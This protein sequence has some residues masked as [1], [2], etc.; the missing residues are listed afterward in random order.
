MKLPPLYAAVDLKTLNWCWFWI[1]CYLPEDLDPAFGSALGRSF[2]SDLKRGRRSV[3]SG[4]WSHF[5]V[6]L[7]SCSVHRTV[8]GLSVHLEAFFEELQRVHRPLAGGSLGHPAFRWGQQ[9]QGC[10]VAKLPRWVQVQRPPG[11][12]H[13]L[14]GLVC[15]AFFF[16]CLSLR[17]SSSQPLLSLTH[18]IAWAL[19]CCRHYS[20][21]AC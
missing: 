20:L 17:I 5:S 8:L 6:L 11:L 3:G 9:T 4:G 10:H 21:W 16:P 18:R 12:P 7:L 15:E 2:L 19:K 14:Y 1:G 13:V